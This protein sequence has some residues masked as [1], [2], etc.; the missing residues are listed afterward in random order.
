MSHRVGGDECGWGGGCLTRI[1]GYLPLDLSGLP[2]SLGGP[3]MVDWPQLRSILAT[4]RH[5]TVSR[6]WP[7]HPVRKPVSCWQTR[8]GGCY[9]HPVRFIGFLRWFLLHS[10]PW[11]NYPLIQQLSYG[12]GCD[13]FNHPEWQGGFSQGSETSFSTSKMHY[14]CHLELRNYCFRWWKYWNF[15]CVVLFTESLEP[16]LRSVPSSSLS[17]FHN[18]SL[19]GPVP[20]SR[21]PINQATISNWGKT[22]H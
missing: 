20:F 8:Q 13:L 4:G 9:W 7:L 3:C 22:T 14:G 15:D 2:A 10:S 16:F 18:Q 19:P 21:H 1:T 17:H 11:G 5:W 6:C 12:E